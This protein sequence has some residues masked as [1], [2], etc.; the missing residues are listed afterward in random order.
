MLSLAALENQWVGR[1]ENWAVSAMALE[2]EGRVTVHD[3]EVIRILES[4]GRLI[5]N[6]DRHSGNLSFFLGD[7]SGA[8]TACS[9]LRYASDRKVVLEASGR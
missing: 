8:G 2:R 1:G 6:S 3:L 5:A 4:F 7:G 9:R